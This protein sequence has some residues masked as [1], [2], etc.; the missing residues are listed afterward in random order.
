MKMSTISRLA[1]L[2]VVP[3]ISLA[4][5]LVLADTSSEYK[6]L[7]GS[8]GKKVADSKTTTDDAVFAAKLLK[9]ARKMPDSPTL[10]ILLYEKAYQFG[11]SGPAGCDNQPNLSASRNNPSRVNSTPSDCR[12]SAVPLAMRFDKGGPIGEKK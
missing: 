1:I 10:Q 6:T 8:E 11:S 7:F 3:V 12:Y 9:A 2:L 4:D 5:S